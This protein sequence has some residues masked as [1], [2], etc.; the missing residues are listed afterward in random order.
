MRSVPYYA[1]ETLPVPA[2]IVETTYPPDGA[3]VEPVSPAPIVIVNPAE[4]F[5]TT[6]PEPP[7]PP[8]CP[9]PSR[10]SPPPPPPPLFAVPAVAFVADTPVP[11]IELP[12]DPAV[13]APLVS[14]PAPPP[15]E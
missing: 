9:V 11:P 13:P 7:A 5:K 8:A 4:Y 6:T 1:Q 12:P 3:D 10:Y 14:I 15:P 2:V